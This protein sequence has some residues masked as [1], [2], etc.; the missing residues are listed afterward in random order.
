LLLKAR[1]NE[2]LA[3]FGEIKGGIIMLEAGVIL[4]RVRAENP[5]VHNITN[6]VVTNFTANGL[7]AMGA[8]PVMAYAR[9][10][11][12]EM[13]GLA[14][15]L[16]LNIGTL[17]E[18]VVE[19]M[20]I[21]GKA[22]NEHQ[23]PVVFDPVGAGATAYRTCTARKL[24]SELDIAVVRGNAAEVANAAGMNWSIK[25]VDSGSGKGNL[26]ELGK[27]AALQFNSVVVITG[28]E[29]VV[30]DGNITYV[31]KNGHHL[32]TK[33]TG[34]GCLLTSVI[35][36]FLAVEKN[37]AKAAAS[38]L[39]FY[40]VAAEKAAGLAA[41]AGP[42]TFQMHLLDSLSL[43]SSNDLKEKA[44]IVCGGEEHGSL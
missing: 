41:E 23:V 21:A 22:A 1:S 5:L 2:D 35:G 33:V 43:V 18:P 44:V 32:L 3:F 6:V 29:D 15:A 7:L 30:T 8:S 16:V 25:G 9:E 4:D 39:A 37:H 31:I 28:P 38:A 13:A 11:A 42:G 20:L 14:G 26:V 10:E 19:S 27:T 24:I 34:A 36:A 12:G 17:N 40:G